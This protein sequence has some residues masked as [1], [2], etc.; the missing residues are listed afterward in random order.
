MAREDCL[1]QPRRISLSTV[2]GV[3]RE[4]TCDYY[5]SYKPDRPCVQ[6]EDERSWKL[7]VRKCYVF[8]SKI[9]RT[10]DSSLKLHENGKDAWQ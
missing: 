10:F 3:W 1:A 4:A 5:S 8:K 2:Q 9:V 7:E 6:A